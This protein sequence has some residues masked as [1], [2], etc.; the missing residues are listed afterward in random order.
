MVF[1]H[2]PNGLL[3]VGDVLFQGSV[4]RTDFPEGDH[5]LLIRSIREKLLPLG[6]RVAIIPGHGPMSTLGD[7]R[8]FNPYLNGHFS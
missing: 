8:R 1:H 5:A 3:I 4:G 6:D 7:E 2:R